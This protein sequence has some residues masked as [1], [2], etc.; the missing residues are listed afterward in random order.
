MARCSL[1]TCFDVEV[2]EAKKGR[3]VASLVVAMPTLQ[4][5]QSGAVYGGLLTC[6]DADIEIKRRRSVGSL[7]VAR[8]T[9]KKP[10]SDESGAAVASSAICWI[11][12]YPGGTS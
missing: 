3:V 12:P 7:L 8:P 6:C 10:K 9:L 4:K 5:S 2:E 11:A 1:N